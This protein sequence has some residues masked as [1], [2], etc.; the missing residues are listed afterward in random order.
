MYHVTETRKQNANRKATAEASSKASFIVLRHGGVLLRK[1]NT[2][3]NLEGEDAKGFI[4]RVRD[5]GAGFVKS[6]VEAC[7]A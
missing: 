2:T 3:K 4:A 5:K 7:F 6:Q 1:G